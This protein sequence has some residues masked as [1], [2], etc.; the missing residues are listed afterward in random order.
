MKRVL[1]A[2]ILIPLVL[3]L[4]FKAPP[5][6]MALVLALIAWLCLREYFAI[7]EAHGIKPFRKL[8]TVFVLLP[9]LPMGVGAG[10]PERVLVILAA[11][12]LGLIF[13][14]APFLL[15]MAGMGRADLR[16]TL[17]GAGASFLAIP[18]IGLSL[19]LLLA[20]RD[21]AGAVIVMHVLVV[22]WVGDI[23]AYYVGKNLGRHKL[24]PRVSPGKT[25]EGAIASALAATA[26]GA[27]ILIN[28]PALLA[29][30]DSF[31]YSP[32]VS[33]YWDAEYA[34][35]LWFAVLASAVINIAAQSGDLVESAIKRG[36][37]VKDSGSLLP[38]HGGML[39]RVDALLFAAPVAWLVFILARFAL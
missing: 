11:L 21:L 3:V 24:A 15:I 34:F 37:E 30:A 29:F 39:D 17:P 10:L 22:V 38:G 18:Y 5:W 1:T 6:L 19:L 35:P 27:P 32:F 9:L 2:A 33:V 25:W 36:A 28:R 13:L 31:L 12:T 14:L 16:S 20:L 8:T 23:A 26:V 7:V 4:V